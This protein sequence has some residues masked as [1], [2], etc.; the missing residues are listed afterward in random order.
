ML[1]VLLS[2]LILASAGLHLRAEYRGLRRHVYLFKPLTTG[3][4]LLLALL[5]ADPPSPF[6]KLAIVASL[7]FSLAGD[8]FLM[9]P[10]DRF[11]A[12]LVSF[13]LAHL[14]YIAAFADPA[15]FYLSP[16]GLL[17]FLLYG[18]FIYRLLWPR[19]GSMKLPA[20]VYMVAIVVMAWQALGQWVQTGQSR[21]LLAF[22]GA[23]LF[24]AS[25]SVLALNRFRKPIP[26]AQA[27]IMSTYFAAQWLIALSVGGA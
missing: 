23:L 12:G 1:P 5:T 8:I 7:A 26:H 18:G 22:V 2:P 25:D 13:L 19:L 17:P 16:W 9:L 6:Y 20:L 14:G 21:A 11:L 27:I 15:G 3:L 24:V 10:A 4:I